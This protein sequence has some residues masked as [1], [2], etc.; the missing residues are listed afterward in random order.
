MMFS[1]KPRF[2][3]APLP[4][5]LL[6]SVALAPPL[7]AAQ[8]A[9]DNDM[10]EV[11]VTAIRSPFSID[12]VPAALRVIDRDTI[13]RSGARDLSDLLRHHGA[14][15]IRDSQGNNRNSQVSLRGFG[16]TANVLILVDGRR[17][18]N[19]DMFHPDLTQ[20]SLANVERIEILEGDAGVVHGDQAVGGVI[21]IITSRAT[22]PRGQASVGIGSFDNRRY[23]LMHENRLEQGLFYRAAVDLERGDGYRREDSID[24]NQYSGRLGYEYDG[25]EL[26]WEGV[27][28]ERDDLLS[29][30]LSLAEIQDDRRQQGSSFNQYEIDTTVHRLVWDHAL[31]EHWR[32][33]VDYSDRD[34]DVSVQ[35][36]FGLTEQ[37]RRN[38]FFA[39]R[40]IWQKD[41]YRVTAGYDWEKVDYDFELAALSAF[42]SQRHRKDSYW[43][44]L[45]LAATERLDFQLGARRAHMDVDV[46]SEGFDY[47][48]SATVFQ[49]GVNWR[50]ERWR[51]FANASQSYRFPLADENID[52]NSGQFSGL[53][54]QKGRNVE[55][56]GERLFDTALLRLSAFEQRTRDEIGLDD[57]LGVNVN[58]DDTRRRGV[59]VEAEW[60]PT[61]RLAFS[62]LYRWMD[63][64]F[65]DGPYE[66]NRLPATSRN[67]VKLQGSFRATEWLDG[68]LEW[69][70]QSV[71]QLDLANEVEQ[72]GYSLANLALRGRWD[73]WTLQARI[74]NL[75]GKR[76]IE[77]RSYSS[78]SGVGYFP[79][80]GRHYSLTLTY[81]F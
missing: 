60:E 78:W 32:I 10:R 59:N 72:G 14:V 27:R 1:I 67:L 22:A 55:V 49:S 61:E 74:N 56:G 26:Y 8:E 5:A 25:G 71:Q 47:R 76:Y 65:R 68:Y 58:F 40:M 30:A 12:Q 11:V 19:P 42:N 35:S 33:L 31:T 4:A 46:K 53:D 34:E 21:N 70:W 75:T 15:Q 23:R 36:N 50:G 63:A 20:V 54:I 2:R 79:S 9:V 41:S 6:A 51:V 28:T 69:A 62:G 45:N 80:P 18:N 29:G 81:D 37:R 13:E 3:L 38:R 43:A 48:Q 73:D 7:V 66:G 52:Y 39:P 16:A 44:Q 17:L 57:A 64:Q 77:Y 24:Y